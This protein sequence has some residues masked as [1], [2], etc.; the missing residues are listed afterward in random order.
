MILIFGL[1]GRVM[2]KVLWYGRIKLQNSITNI[3][4]KLLFHMFLVHNDIIFYLKPK[5]NDFTLT[6]LLVVRNPLPS[7]LYCSLSVHT[8]PIQLV[9]IKWVNH[10]LKHQPNP[11]NVIVK[12][13]ESGDE[14]SYYW[15]VLLHRQSLLILEFSKK[16][17]FNFV[18]LG[19]ENLE[20]EKCIRFSSCTFTTW[21]S[22]SLFIRKIYLFVDMVQIHITSTV[23]TFTH[24]LN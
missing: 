22:G 8:L 16:T 12:D 18:F 9:H 4:T 2:T 3:F 11:K 13:W 17:D 24:P 6:L 15:P 21:K 1:N 14:L 5:S 20:F 10:V 19:Y 7:L 23:P